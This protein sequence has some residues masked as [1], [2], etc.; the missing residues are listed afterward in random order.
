MGVLLSCALAAQQP[1]PD[2]KKK[3][4]PKPTTQQEEDPPEE[5]VASRPREYPFNPLQANKS[6]TAG[7]YY[8]KKGNFAAAR[9]RY[10]DATKFNP[11][12]ADAYLKL[13]EALEKL[14]DKKH[15]RAVY[16]KYIELAQDAKST[17]AI[18]KKIE[19]WPK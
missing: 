16:E 18:K 1:P 15:A 9:D 13:G 10:D 4:P 2:S 3:P 5:D 17:D 12:S 8:F 11:G 14:N 19:K 6:I 7:N